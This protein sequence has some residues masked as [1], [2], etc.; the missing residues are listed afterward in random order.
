MCVGITDLKE[1]CRAVST[2][3]TEGRE[4]REH[5]KGLLLFALRTPKEY[6]IIIPILAFNKEEYL[7][8][9]R[10]QLVV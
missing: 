10:K 4:L 6:N 9:V 8:E 1:Q 3:Q 5:H 2:R 7:F